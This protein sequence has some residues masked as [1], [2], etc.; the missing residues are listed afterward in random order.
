MN[1]LQRLLISGHPLFITHDGFRQTMCAEFPLHGIVAAHESEEK[2]LEKVRRELSYMSNVQNAH[3][4]DEYE[5]SNIESGSVA[6]H[7]VIGFVTADCSWLFSSKRLESNLRKAED[8]PQIG[9]HLLHIDTQGGEAWYLDRLSETFQ[10]CKK[11]I[12]A[13]VEGSCCSAGYHIACHAQKIYA[14][15]ANDYIGCIGTMVSFYDFEP[16]F[17]KLGIKKVEARATKSD[18]K[19][20]EFQQLRDG[21]SKEFVKDFLDPMNEEFLNTVCSQREALGKLEKD[22]PVLRGK[23]YTTYPAIDCGLIDGMRTLRQVVDECQLLSKQYIS[24]IEMLQASYQI[25]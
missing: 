9:C 21:D 12:L 20:Q 10:E 15:T 25:I 24:D 23:T 13:F 7:P 16:Y 1:Y 8:N 5:N 22:N 17:E 4:T 3:L 18:L 19:N 6:Y 14:C 2:P 11:P